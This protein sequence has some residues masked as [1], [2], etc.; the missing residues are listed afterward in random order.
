MKRYLFCVNNS[1]R[2]GKDAYI[3]RRG[4]VALFLEMKGLVGLSDYYFQCRLYEESGL[5]CNRPPLLEEHGDDQ[6][7]SKERFL[8]KSLTF[9][10]VVF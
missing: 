3:Q 9:A 1:C 4:P 7:L 2:S 8:C 5:A 10:S 6:Y